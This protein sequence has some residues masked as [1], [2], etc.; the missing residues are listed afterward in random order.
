MLTYARESLWQGS[1][2]Y[3]FYTSAKS[4]KPQTA[5][6]KASM[7]GTL[8]IDISSTAAVKGALFVFHNKDKSNG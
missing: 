5:G 3:W 1:V 6:T 2:V 7:K 8:K 4:G